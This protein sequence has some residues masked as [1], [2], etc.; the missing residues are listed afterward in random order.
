MG[1]PDTKSLF[2]AQLTVVERWVDTPVA[3]GHAERPVKFG[4]AQ[5]GA[6][7]GDRS[8]I[9]PDAIMKPLLSNPTPNKRGVL[10]QPKM[11]LLD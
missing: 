6:G 4:A 3:H 2:D 10:C 1:M 7:H 5:L 9:R 8:T 11:H